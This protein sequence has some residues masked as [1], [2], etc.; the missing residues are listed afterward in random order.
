M[1]KKIQKKKS[2]K[3]DSPSV[4]R[5]FT[6]QIKQIMMAIGILI[7][8]VAVSAIA[9]RHFIRQAPSPKRPAPQTSPAAPIHQAHKTPQPPAYKIY[10]QDN[11]RPNNLIPES[12]PSRVSMKPQV[13][14][15]IDDI[16][17]DKAIAEKFLK[18]D[19]PLTISI[20]PFSP[21][22]KGIVRS[23]HAKGTEIMLHL[24]MEPTEYPRIDPGPGALLTSMNPDELI[25]QLL[26]DIHAVNGI[27]GVNN[28]MGSKMTSVSTQMYQIFTILKKQN[29]YFIDSRTTS[30]SLCNPSARLLQ[31]PFAQRDVFLDHKQDA[32]FIRNQINQLIHIAQ[33]N[34]T[35][36]AIAHPHSIT[37]TVLRESLPELKKHLTIVS[38]STLTRIIE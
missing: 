2:K 15:I 16:G 32:T 7:L 3:R 12:K 35:A 21:F 26:K 37:Y 18:L 23:A 29:L 10:P 5:S 38:A 33:K 27:K 28:H 25:D 9:I 34:G 22:Q 1:A 20:L 30:L 13:A 19:I 36:V 8:V 11:A 24:P 14:I 31:I 6:D 17:Y 4:S